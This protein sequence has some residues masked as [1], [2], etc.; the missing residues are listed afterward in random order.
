[1]ACA[2]RDVEGVLR[3]GF[4]EAWVYFKMGFEGWRKNGAFMLQEEMNNGT[5]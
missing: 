5:K 1:M 3:D 4:V 2:Q